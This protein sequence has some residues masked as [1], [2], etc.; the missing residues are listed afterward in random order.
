[1]N[2]CAQLPVS[3]IRLIFKRSDLAILELRGGTHLLLFEAKQ[4]PEAGPLRSFDFMVDD[5]TSTRASFEAA[6]MEVTPIKDD[7]IS[8]HQMLR[9]L[10]RMGMQSRYCRAYRRPRRVTVILIVDPYGKREM[11]IPGV[12]ETQTIASGLRV[13][14]GALDSLVVLQAVL[15]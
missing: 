12:P 1:M 10:I 13:S 3:A 8:G 6:G 4:K 11:E 14:P 15:P 2:E 7:G 5:I 9:V